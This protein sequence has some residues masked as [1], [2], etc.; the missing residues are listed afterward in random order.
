M[1]GR[2]CQEQ[3]EG[4][5]A[6][7]LLG[8]GDPVGDPDPCTRSW[9]S[10]QSS[11]SLQLPKECGIPTHGS[12]DRGSTALTLGLEV[13]DDGSVHRRHGQGQS[14]VSQLHVQAHQPQ[15]VLPVQGPHGLE[16]G[17]S[18]CSEQISQQEPLSAGLLQT[19]L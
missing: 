13:Q 16:K 5:R 14:A 2:H 10:C 11:Q 12:T 17:G 18:S 8:A 4:S 19:P 9:S 15:V 3:A 6:V 7:A 1:Q